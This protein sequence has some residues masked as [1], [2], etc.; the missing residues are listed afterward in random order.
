MDCIRAC[1]HDNIGVVTVVPG[2]DLARDPA[3]S[4]VGR[5]SKRTDL[6][7]MVVVVV[8]AAFL[9]AA[10]MIGPVLELEH[11]VAA[12][13]GLAGPMAVVTGETLLGVLVAP[14]VAVAAA[15]AA[16]RWLSGAG[17]GVLA[18]ARRFAYALVPL[19]LGMWLAHFSF[20]FFTSAGTLAPALQRFACDLGF[21]GF[22]RPAWAA[23]SAGKAGNWLLVVQ[24]LFLDLGL[25]GSLHAAYRIARRDQP[26]AAMR[27]LAPWAALAL[28][29][30]A[31]G[32]WILFQPM[33]MRGTMT[34]DM[35]GM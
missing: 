6:A 33:Q 26:R 23:C 11:R 31:A 30:F 1:P 32:I 7:V 27:A 35:G 19:G 16:S 15:A 28:L 34:M 5:F 2:A 24:I 10:E 17:E 29:L 18:T 3:R 20:H 8:F 22:G 14:A 25:L 13:L 21:S 12:R 4:G 9:N